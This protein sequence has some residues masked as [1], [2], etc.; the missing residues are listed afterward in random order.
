MIVQ[1][2]PFWNSGRTTS[3]KKQFC[4][5]LMWALVKNNFL[6]KITKEK[7]SKYKDKI[8]HNIQIMNLE[9]NY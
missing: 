6:H 2:E 4:K 3:V 9:P 8:T 1:V 5:L 7:V